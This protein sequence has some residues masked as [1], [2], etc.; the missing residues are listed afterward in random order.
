MTESVQ[1][2]QKL[3]EENAEFLQS[4]LVGVENMGENL[5]KFR[6]EM[7]G[8]KS[9]ELQ[10]AEREYEAVNEEL[11]TEVSLSIPAVTEPMQI[12]FTPVSAPQFPVNPTVP[13]SHSSG[14]A[15]DPE[16]REMQERLSAIR[17]PKSGASIRLVSGVQQ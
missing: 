13:V 6:E 9:A 15:S 8:W 16:L 5:K 17:K 4:L 11:L 1:K 14:I 3:A 7:E 2:A 10:N 12:P